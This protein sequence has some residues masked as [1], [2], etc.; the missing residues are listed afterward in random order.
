MEQIGED[1]VV[2]PQLQKL[3]A[4]M[5]GTAVAG[6]KSPELCEEQSLQETKDITPRPGDCKNA[7]QRKD[8]MKAKCVCY[9]AWVYKEEPAS[10]LTS[11]KPGLQNTLLGSI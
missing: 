11:M 5:K 4:G 7:S 6:A 2:G 8:K 9:L 10:R 3:S 1:L